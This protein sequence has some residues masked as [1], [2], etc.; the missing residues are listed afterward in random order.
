MS[1]TNEITSEVGEAVELIK[2]YALELEG[3]MREQAP[4]YI[5][6]VLRWGLWNHLLYTLLWLTLVIVFVIMARKCNADSDR[7]TEK[8]RAME[9][10]ACFF[11]CMVFTC[12]A[13]L[14]SYFTVENLFVVMKIL[15][16]PRLYLLEHFTHLIK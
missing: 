2:G 13:I 3:F 7:F 15:V 10:D 4:L 16:A 11:F 9:A 1:K 8:N 6:E 14:F 12:L 5:E